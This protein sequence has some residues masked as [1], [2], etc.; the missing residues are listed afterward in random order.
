L[1]DGVDSKDL[2]SSRSFATAAATSSINR[3]NVDPGVTGLVG[4][5]P[6]AFSRSCFF[7]EGFSFLTRAKCARKKTP[8]VGAGV[9][10]RW[11]LACDQIVGGT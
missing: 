11:F 6:L 3:Y 1:V 5:A 10:F 7:I 8:G 2:G 4:T 9:I